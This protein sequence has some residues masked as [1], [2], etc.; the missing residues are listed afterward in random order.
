MHSSK[1]QTQEYTRHDFYC[2][3]VLSKKVDVKIEFE[4]KNVLAFHHTKPYWPTHIVVIPKKHISSLLTLNESDNYILIEL[5]GVIKQVAQKLT[6][7][8]GES[9]VL[10][11]L[12]NYQDSKHLHFHVSTGKPL[13]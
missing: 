13:K 3:M 7:E 2:D 12:G 6:Q 10:T 5:I 4:T 11:N 9:R 1:I 8:Y